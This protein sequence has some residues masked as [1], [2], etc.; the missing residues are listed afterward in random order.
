M[1]DFFDI[2]KLVLLG[3]FCIL[4]LISCVFCDKI[5]SVYNEKMLVV[6]KEV[7]YM[8]EISNK[9]YASAGKLWNEE[10]KM[11]VWMLIK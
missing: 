3:H 5:S 2:I 4:T 9:D 6:G 7:F 1:P 11:A 10:S 8:S